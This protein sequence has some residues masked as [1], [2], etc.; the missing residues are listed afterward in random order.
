VVAFNTRVA[1]NSHREVAFQP[2]DEIVDEFWRETPAPVSRAA[3]LDWEVEM[4]LGKVRS[5]ASEV[6]VVVGDESESIGTA[7]QMHFVSGP[8]QKAGI[9]E[10]VLKRHLLSDE[11]RVDE[12]SV[13][14]ALW[15][16]ATGAN[17]PVTLL[18]HLDYVSSHSVFT[19]LTERKRAESAGGIWRK[20]IIVFD[21]IGVHRAH[22]TLPSNVVV[23]RSVEQGNF[24][25]RDQ[26]RREF[27]PQRKSLPSL[28]PSRLPTG[29][30]PERTTASRTIPVHTRHNDDSSVNE[31]I[32]SFWFF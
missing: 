22:E 1:M 9:A 27:H 32:S 4:T 6:E 14:G 31:S 30:T 8:M 17:Y 11:H 28:A 13:P 23:C 19:E 29:K 26:M 21:N 18:S 12:L 16:V 2:L 25:A 15:I 20:S 10:K 3:F 5:I 24:T 7:D